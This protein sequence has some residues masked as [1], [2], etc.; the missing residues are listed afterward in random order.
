[1]PASPGQGRVGEGAVLISV[2]SEKRTDSASPAG[3][4]AS[5]VSVVDGRPAS[6]SRISSGGSARTA[7]TRSLLMCD[8]SSSPAGQPARASAAMSSAARIRTIPSGPGW[9]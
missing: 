6:G 3:V 1:M 9:E 4:T 2:Q 5:A 7:S 8:C